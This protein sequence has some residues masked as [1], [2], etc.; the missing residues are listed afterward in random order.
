M[1]STVR[2]GS[3]WPEGNAG[4]S[5]MRDEQAG[6]ENAAD[7]SWAASD[8]E[9]YRAVSAETESEELRKEVDGLR[10]ALASHPVIDMARGIVMATAACTPEQAWQLLVDVSQHSNVKLRE[11]ARHIVD[12]VNGPPP[13]PAVRTALRAAI[14]ALHGSTG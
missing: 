11:V 7:A 12:S 2:D 3:A 6:T 14:A 13:P 5:G 10:Q 1:P 4:M 8:E 9:Q